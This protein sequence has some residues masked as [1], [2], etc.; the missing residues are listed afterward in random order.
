VLYEAFTSED[1]T[2][3]IDAY[4]KKRVPKFKGA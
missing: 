1:A 4:L 3:G 2:E